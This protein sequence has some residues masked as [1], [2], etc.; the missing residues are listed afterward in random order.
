MFQGYAVGRLGKDAELKFTTQGTPVANFSLAVEIGFG[1]RKKT[2]WIECAVWG[3][4][5][6]AL[7]PY[8][9]KGKQVA[10]TGEIDARAWLSDRDKEP[11]ASVQLN[12]DKLT[13]CGD[14]N[15]EGK[16]KGGRAA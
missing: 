6:E 3:K 7:E 15:S 5:A 8:L 13:L 12:V 14:S 1:D 9:K 4:M 16:S 2:L 10:V 11:H